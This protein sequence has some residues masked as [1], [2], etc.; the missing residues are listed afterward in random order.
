[1]VVGSVSFYIPTVVFMFTLFV[2]TLFMSTLFMFTLFMF[3][4]R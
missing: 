3:D 1:M 2:F 4:S